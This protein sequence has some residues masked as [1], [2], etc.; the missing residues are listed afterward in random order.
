MR[1]KLFR[2]LFLE[3]LESRRLL[4]SYYVA[5]N[6]NDSNS[7]SASAP[8]LTIQNAVQTVVPGDTVIVRAGSYVGF[9]AGYDPTG[10]YGTIAGTASAPI[11][12]EADPTATPGTVI[13]NNHNNKTHV[14]ADLE[15]GCDYITISGFTIDG[16][17]GIAN[18]PDKGS[19]IK[20]TGNHDV[21]INNTVKNIDYGFGITCDNSVGIVI[22]NNTV[23]GIGSHG[24]GNYG[25]GIYV[26]G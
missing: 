12:F 6:G 17:G 20:A 3:E 16:A 15:P 8:W 1:K 2:R 18:Y 10:T 22:Q 26:A 4:S 13:I 7:G 11:T 25:H 24:N 14:A 21:I 9:I 5:S 23:F 19:G